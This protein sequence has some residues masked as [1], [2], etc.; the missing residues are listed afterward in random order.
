MRRGN[1]DAREEGRSRLFDSDLSGRD[2]RAGAG[3]RA[4]PAARSA[5]R[6]SR[7]RFDPY[8]RGT[9]DPALNAGKFSAVTGTTGEKWLTERVKEFQIASQVIHRARVTT[10]VYGASS[11]APSNVLFGDRALLLDAAQRSGASP[12]IC[13][14]SIASSPTNRSRSRFAR[15]DEDLRLLVDRTLSRLYRSGEA[16]ALYAKWLGEPDANTLTFFRLTA[17]PD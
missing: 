9:V 12:R 16:G 5:G 15:G 6:P 4:R 7:D 14:S 17:L 10:P 13:S 1:R 2:R 11:T 3:G 8:W